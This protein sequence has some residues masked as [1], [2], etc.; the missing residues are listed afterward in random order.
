[1]SE[2]LTD[3]T[4][5]DIMNKFLRTLVWIDDEIRPDKLDTDGDPFRNFFFPTAQ[6]FQRMNLLVHLHPFASELSSGGENIYDEEPPPLEPVITLAK[7]AD[8]IILDWHLGRDDPEYSIKL[9]K[10]INDEPAIRYIVVLSHFADDF[11]QEMMSNGMLV[12]TT[13]STDDA[14]L[15]TDIYGAW[16][17]EQGTHVIAIKKPDAVNYSA[18]DFCRTVITNIYDLMTHAHP[19]YLHWAAMEIAAKMRHSIPGWIKAIPR[20]T[21]P[22]VLS[23]LMSEES[24]AREFIPEHLLEDLSNLARLNVLSSLDGRNCRQEH[25]LYPSYNIERPPTSDRRADKAVHLSIPA[26]KLVPADIE[27]IRRQVSSDHGS[28]TYINSQHLFEGFCENMSSCPDTNPTFGSVYTKDVPN[29]ST[30]PQDRIGDGDQSTI[31]LCLS[32]ECD[33]LRRKSLLL[34]I[35]RGASPSSSRRGGVTKLSF[36]GKVFEFVHEAD[37]IQTVVVQEVNGKRTLDGYA[38]IGQ[39]RKATA[40]RIINRYWS[41]MSRSAVNLS[42]FAL[43]DRQ[44]E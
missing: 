25:W 35:G 23:E 10:M 29:N 6:E 12:D 11:R 30:N 39:V 34:L 21:D 19:D 33:A 43:T 18:E 20:G 9:L 4:R 41:H 17:N 1:M 31:Y 5:R 32:Q 13:G 7:K 15:F 38:K 16:A 27:A 3:N 2:N 40:R 22:A 8:V 36:G 24:E 37:S 26:A 44:A 42:R 14:S 28:E